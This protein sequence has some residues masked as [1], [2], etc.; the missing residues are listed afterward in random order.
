MC[1][2]FFT[3]CLPLAVGAFFPETPTNIYLPLFDR[4]NDNKRTFN[5]DA[6]KDKQ[7]LNT[8]INAET[9]WLMKKHNQT[10]KCDIAIEI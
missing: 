7:E 9:H 8:Q 4:E 10:H 6:G 3:F 2:I 5:V 1:V